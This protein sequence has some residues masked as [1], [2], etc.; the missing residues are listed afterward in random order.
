MKKK[1]SE[2]SDD[3]RAEYDFATLK[4]VACGRG[5]KA[6]N[7]VELAPDVAKEFPHRRGRE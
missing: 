7:T 1:P 3:L 4:I 6:P 2:E 5:R